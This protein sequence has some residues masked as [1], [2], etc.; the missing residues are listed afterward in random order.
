M[1]SKSRTSNFSN[2]TPEMQ[3]HLTKKK[4]GI[5][6][7]LREALD[8][9]KANGKLLSGELTPE[10]E[11]SYKRKDLE[12]FVEHTQRQRD[13]HLADVSE[14]YN[15]NAKTPDY[16]T[17]LAPSA[18]TYEARKEINDFEKTKRDYVD[19]FR[20]KQ[21]EA[22]KQ[23]PLSLGERL[24]YINARRHNAADLADEALRATSE[25]IIEST[26]DTAKAV[27]TLVDEL[28]TYLHLDSSKDKSDVLA[29]RDE[30][31][32]RMQEARNNAY[33]RMRG[34][35]AAAKELAELEAE[36]NSRTKNSP[37]DK[38]TKGAADIVSSVT[39]QIP[40]YALHAIPAVGST[41]A[42]L[43]N[44]SISAPQA[45]AEARD[46]GATKEQA[47]KYSRLEGVIQGAGDYLISGSLGLGKGAI[48]TAVNKITKGAAGELG[49]RMLNSIAKK[50]LAKAVTTAAVK[51][52]GEGVE[53]VLQGIMSTAA[54]RATYAPNKRLN[55]NELA[56]EGLLGAVTAGFFQLADLPNA[57]KAYKYDYDLVNAF[58]R[59]AARVQNDAEADVVVRAGELIIDLADETINDR[60]TSADDRQRATFIKDGVEQVVDD[61]RGYKDRIIYDNIE[62]SDITDE[63][64]HNSEADVN[65]NLA[66]L[67]MRI[68]EDIAPDESAF[69]ATVDYLR[70]RISTLETEIEQNAG[71]EEVV[72]AKRIEAAALREVENAL[73]TNRGEIEDEIKELQ[74]TEGLVGDLHNAAEGSS[75][76]DSGVSE[77]NAVLLTE[78]ST[79]S[80]AEETSDTVKKQPTVKENEAEVSERAV[81]SA[82]PLDSGENERIIESTKPV[83]GEAVPEPETQTAP[84]NVTLTYVQMKHPN[85]GKTLNVFRTSGKL[86]KE[87]YVGI[88]DK[89]KQVGGY[90][91]RFAQGFVIPESKMRASDAI[92]AVSRFANVAV[93]KSPA[94]GT[95][96][97]SA[98]LAETT[99]RNAANV[100]EAVE[101]VE[102]ESESTEVRPTEETVE[103]TQNAETGSAISDITS[104]ASRENAAEAAEV[105]VASVPGGE[106]QEPVQQKTSRKG[107][108]LPEDADRL[109][110]QKLTMDGHEF[111]VESVDRVSHD[112]YM[113]DTNDS[114]AEPKTE[115]YDTVVKALEEQKNSGVTAPD[116]PTTPDVAT[117]AD[118]VETA[119][120]VEQPVE[121]TAEQSESVSPVTSEAP[122]ADNAP[123]EV[124][125][126][127][128]TRSETEE[129]KESLKKAEDITPLDTLHVKLSSADPT[130]T[131]KKI[132]KLFAKKRNLV[133]LEIG[134]QKYVSDQA[135]MI[136]VSDDE[137]S[138]FETLCRDKAKEVT[139][140]TYP[141][142]K[143]KDVVMQRSPA[144]PLKQS[145][146]KVYSGSSGDWVVF[147]GTDDTETLVDLKYVKYFDSP[148]NIWGAAES[149][150]KGLKFII[151]YD[152][153]SNVNGI[154]APVKPPEIPKSQSDVLPFKSKSDFLK[155]PTVEEKR[156]TETAKEVTTDVPQTATATS[157]EG[158]TLQTENVA[159]D[160]IL[161][162]YYGAIADRIVAEYLETNTPLTM[163]ALQKISSDVYGGTLAE[164][165]FSVKDMTDALELAVNR[166][167][168]KQMSDNAAQYNAGT[169]EAALQGLEW[170][171]RLLE[172]I[173]TQ[174]K[175]TEEQV[176]LQQFSTPPNIAYLAGWLANIG[177]SDFMLEPSAGIGGLASFAK[178]F[179]AVT[180]VNE[181]S[182]RRLG[183]LR[184]LGFDHVFSEDA[185][186]LDN[187]LPD[188]VKP[189]VIVMNPPFSSTG[190]R[191]KNSTQ[192]AKPHVEQALARL[193]DGGRLVA[194][195]G[196]GMSNDA[197]MFAAWWDS[198]RKQGYN[199][200][201]NIGIDGS[202]YRKYGTTFNVRLV[203]IDKDGGNSTTVTGDFKSLS[204]IPKIMEEIRNGR[205]HTGTAES[206]RAVTSNEKTGKPG[207]SGGTQ[208]DTGGGNVGVSVQDNNEHNR[209]QM[210]QVRSGESTGTDRPTGMVAQRS[211]NTV[212]GT[213]NTGSLGS[214]GGRGSVDGRRVS[215]ND[216]INGQRGV[217]TGDGV[218]RDAGRDADV[219]RP[220]A[221]VPRA[222]V[223]KAAENKK[224]VTND[225]GVY[226]EYV[227]SKLTVE[228]VKK[229]PASLVESS[230]M[231]AISAPQITYTP[232]IAQDIIDKGLLSD[233]QLENISYAGQAHEQMLEDGSRKGFFIGDGTGVGK[234]RQAAGIILDNFN[235]GRRKALWVSEKDG[236]I[237]D[238][239]RD[240]RDIGGDPDDIFDF[241]QISGKRKKQIPENGILFTTYSTVRS[242]KSAN[243]KTTNADTIIKWLGKD[244]DGV[245]IYD[246]A[247]NMNSLIPEP[248]KKTALQAIESNKIQES[249]PNA[250]VVYMSATGATE[251][252]DL[253]FASRLGLWGPGTQFVNAQDFS[254]KIGA[255]GVAGMELVASS[256]KSMGVYQARS[257]SYD[258]VTY[259]TITHQLTQVQHQIYDTMSEAWQ[260][261]LQ[262]MEQA[263]RATGINNART[264]RGAFYSA[265][266]NFYKQVLA[267]MA[268][269]SVM[270]D[271]KKE[272]AAGRSCIIQLVNTNE[273]QQDR[274]LS[275]AKAE[276]VDLDELDI[277]PRGALLGFLEKSF[278]VQQYEDYIDNHGNKSSRPVFDSNGRPVLNK[279]AVKARDELI[280]RIN[281]MSV[282]EGPIDMI[283]NT[284]GAENVAEVTGRRRRV[285]TKTDENGD[286]RKVEE[287]LDKKFRN[288]EAEAF[289]NGGKRILIFS[290]AG[291][292]GRSFHAD[293]RAKNQQQRVVYVLQ[294]GWDPKKTVQGFGRAHR[295]NQVSEPIYKLVQINV[296]GYKRFISSIAR[297][298]DQLGALTKGQRQTG[299]GIFGEKDNLESPLSCDALREFY[300]RLG[301]GQ[302]AGLDGEGVFTRLGLHK[303]F[304]DKNGRF[305]LSKDKAGDITTFLNRL[306]ALKVDE[307]NAVY[308]EFEAIRQKMYDIA[309]DNGTLDRGIGNVKAD[310]ITFDR[311]ETVYI[312]EKT[313]AETKYVKATAY[314]KPKVIATVGDAMAFRNNFQGLRR[315]QDGS[316]RAVYRISDETDALGRV[317]KYFYL[318][319]PDSLVKSRYNEGT[320]R[321]QTTVIP[322]DEWDTAWAEEI[323]NLP[324]FNE[325]ELHIIAGAIL[326][327]WNKLPQ[328]GNIKAVKIVANDGTQ[329]LGRIIP[330]ASIGT[331]L[332]DLDVQQ[333]R[334]RLTGQQMYDAVMKSGKE[335]VFDNDYTG[336]KIIR[337]SRVANENRLEITG[338]NLWA[339]VKSYPYIITE[340]INHQ[341]RYF[342]P[343]GKKGIEFLN[344]IAARSIIRS[345][346]AEG[347]PSATFYSTA[348]G[349]WGAGADKGRRIRSVSDLK[350]EAE[351][352]FGIPINT[353]RMG[354]ARN[355]RGIYKTHANTIRTR[356]YGDLPT[357]AH[358][359]GHHFEQKYELA[360]APETESLVLLYHDVLVAGGYNE[361]VY[362]H[363]AVANYFADFMRDMQGARE[364]APKFTD[365][366]LSKLS[367]EDREKL[368]KYAELTNEYHAAD[369]Q[370]RREAQVKYRTKEKSTLQQAQFQVDS[371]LQNPGAYMGRLSEKFVRNWIDD[372][373]DLK[374]FGKTY[375]L[376]M[377]S[378]TAN[379]IAAGRLTIAFTDR[380]GNVIGKSLKAILA[381]GDINDINAKQFDAYLIAR[382]ALDR[383]EAAEAGHDV[384]TLVYADEELQDKANII[385][386]I[387]QYEADNPTFADCSAEI[388]QYCDNLLDISVGSGII[389]E[390]LSDYLKETF[391]HYVPL[392]RVISKDPRKP[393]MKA[394]RKPYMRFRGSGRDIYSPVENIMLYTQ[395][396]TAAILQND[397]KRAFA[398]FIDSNKDM[399]WAAEKIENGRLVIKNG[400]GKD[401]QK[402]EYDPAELDVEKIRNATIEEK[403]ELVDDVM[404]FIADASG[405]L[406][407]ETNS[408][409]NAIFVM[410]GGKREYYEI[411]DPDL[412]T[413]LSSMNPAQTSF[414]LRILG[415]A[416]NITKM[417]TTGNNPRFG[418]TNVARDLQSGYISSNTTNNPV[419]YV[420]DY[421]KA[422]IEAI[423]ES[424]DFKEFLANGGGYQGAF[425]SDLRNM[426]HVY[427]DVVQT[428][429]GTKRFINFVTQFIPRLIDS[430]EAASRYAEYKRG[431]EQG[432]TSTEALRTAQEITTNFQR[433]GKMGKELDKYVL[434]FNAS[435]QSLYHLYE[436]FHL[437]GKGQAKQKAPAFAK[438]LATNFIG[439]A[440]VWATLYLMSQILDDDDDPFE[441]YQNLSTYNKNAY[442]CFYI[443]NGEFWRIAKPKDMTTL[444]TLVN[445][446]LELEV[447]DNPS[448]F[449][450]VWSYLI[451]TFLPASPSDIVVAGTWVDLAKNETFTGAPIVPTAYQNLVPELQ[452]NERTSSLAV[453]LG[454]A[455]NL[456]PMQID[457]VLDDT[458][459]WVGDTIIN[460]SRLVEESKERPP[461]DTAFAFARAALDTDE[462]MR[463]N[464]AV[465]DSVYSTDIISLFYDTK[466][467]YDKGSASYKSTGEDTKQYRFY[468]TYG[469][470]KYGKV[471]AMYSDVN[472]RIKADE[473][474]ESARKTRAA[475]NTLIKS[476][477]E[478]SV[479]E[480][481][482]A[483]A[484]IAQE[485]GYAV[486]DIAPY[487][488]VPETLSQ[489]VDGVKY[490]YTLDAEDMM[491]YYTESQILFEALYPR[492]ITSGYSAK[493]IAEA[494]V[495]AKKLVNSSMRDRYLEYL[496]TKGVKE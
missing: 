479:T 98:E 383:I 221:G 384:G 135:V 401:A 302:I 438:A 347:D 283:L 374:P 104:E 10:E 163:N 166:Y 203:V 188:F 258:G 272:L 420:V 428:V 391:P 449:Y 474:S 324:E 361:S 148:Q 70:E 406:E 196:Q 208:P 67:T 421:I 131:A 17:L 249:L 307:Q 243:A 353:G 299:S 207:V 138:A 152:S 343:T 174:T 323:K 142:P 6:P 81:E 328:D 404:R 466:D 110:G 34:Q 88:K 281:E 102:A 439:A 472:K 424:E 168:I 454:S 96:G 226:A 77:D 25:S 282:P 204:D 462:K 284:F 3:A 107:V 482:E 205:T 330:S 136:R 155:V 32:Q 213:D 43:Y 493:D 19:E 411:H 134:G 357:I 288:A 370:R 176:S 467:K 8:K 119:A 267:S 122:E 181:I 291:S 271:I 342:V 341:K 246:E 79:G 317:V 315:M 23:P 366:L 65:R 21:E 114:D 485:T 432:K 455:L 44:A 355:V 146:Q 193:E 228:G 390:E 125:T 211:T 123:T 128:P 322:Q 7:E 316:V 50:P 95:Q 99:E 289:Q 257:I 293:R 62:Y 169:A 346:S 171:E 251:V 222:S 365:Y 340:Y 305:S 101:A 183:A 382:I 473:N 80:S 46:S 154:I 105:T 318:Q 415:K 231:A 237:E 418:L 445:S 26:I 106:V 440:L 496:P 54:K 376:T 304:Y 476:V 187:I 185:A 356:V 481:D 461:L 2:L 488:V 263:I 371:F 190:G 224:A 178:A 225:D 235:Q 97:S 68:G 18:E 335:I 58:S 279:Q 165:T 270:E 173:P 200:R 468:D 90:W 367:K 162:T 89:I 276:G 261:T 277:T 459:G 175:R 170:A 426:K 450:D 375:D 412:M 42:A 448:A 201:A 435:I 73:R 456:S 381:D 191:T 156:G 407:A 71:N 177:S 278:P 241:D 129:A 380:E 491:Q 358:E 12:N 327:I 345:N 256:L 266:Q 20:K 167:I 334:E 236:L 31:Q 186:Q 247:H 124:A 286:S 348:N 326:P 414:T 471:A 394:S 234:G 53:E 218:S 233:V 369:L 215:G 120:A 199:I 395:A 29:L 230:A 478:T 393:Y 4:Q 87:E 417:L 232:K 27:P 103:L 397:S 300:K 470:Y 409:K 60:S 51:S 180:A 143:L 238:A 150:H 132:M 69:E 273:A 56:Y 91:N 425:T 63:I 458:T 244:F 250:R 433:H 446:W 109:I 182:E 339:V 447:L 210:V 423:T 245:I 464:S 49:K 392:Y 429:S 158:E 39:Q 290:D 319:S 55:A 202:N 487:I 30:T 195:L 368:I 349:R 313:G 388:Y 13:E 295:S 85:T 379:S 127:T 108:I 377:R 399:G 194:I 477:N 489:K 457:Y 74:K 137:L 463:P 84:K 22:E 139:E 400:S 453:W 11:K 157:V 64:I 45:Y 308:D 116:V 113:R 160:S 1:A 490:V 398:D 413:A 83:E 469:S 209:E 82:E 75:K 359:I 92:N 159:T 94:Q 117:T 227:P 385:K 93:E 197:P 344:D 192:N 255:S 494:M 416:T 78:T 130:K 306:L 337:R 37:L 172:R 483:V 229:H 451:D 437:S 184:S 145:P 486:A 465:T 495:E 253:A 240:W 35:S 66:R 311:E 484:Q 140:V 441:A 363:E 480:I 443:G 336:N 296:N 252:S 118:T 212:H 248:G 264:A 217:G 41:A 303:D 373:V 144:L 405:F 133:K 378:R 112:V 387:E 254:T 164:G 40:A 57:Y 47:E 427:R 179:G 452:Y 396:V 298:L 419:K 220:V 338:V 333:K 147:E 239:K 223:A 36:F 149:G 24:D 294:P 354:R 14:R 76:E 52:A 492:L 350:N 9:R 430:G 422:F 280:A 33:E 38:V 48:D 444:G 5:T 268:T 287:V 100:N 301:K 362:P 121:A 126:E 242:G 285:V 475:L 206:N 297:R 15:V 434:Y 309:I 111:E 259:E 292:T 351:R 16:T 189:T 314:R 352:I 320:M 360:N 312:D 436:T 161:N 214:R 332:R 262:N 219:V 153:N 141:N 28:K 386:A 431:I 408:G 403:A 115:D 389:S 59:K 72:A 460:F 216:E 260:I 275:R 372:I 329:L 61:L 151:S 402:V 310:K 86:S 265:M 274:E 321:E 410:R 364:K 198:L 442:W 325:S 269:P 331:V